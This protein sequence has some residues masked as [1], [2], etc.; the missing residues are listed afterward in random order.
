VIGLVS[1]MTGP[2]CVKGRR[3]RVRLFCLPS[4]TEDLG[5][6]QGRGAQGP[7]ATVLRASAEPSRALCPKRS[8]GR[9]LARS[10]P[11][12]IIESQKANQNAWALNGPKPLL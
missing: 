9:G 11:P 3:P 8:Q 2:F 10:G 4:G 7:G 12:A 5:R 1:V 6:Y